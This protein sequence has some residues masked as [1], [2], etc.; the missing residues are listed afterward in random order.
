MARKNNS[1]TEKRIKELEVLVNKEGLS[2][3]TTGNRVLAQSPQGLKMYIGSKKA[4][5]DKEMF[6]AAAGIRNYMTKYNKKPEEKHLENIIMVAASSKESVESQQKRAT[7]PQAPVLVNVAPAPI[8]VGHRSGPEPLN[9]TIKKSINKG[10]I[11]TSSAAHCKKKGHNIIEDYAKQLGVELDYRYMSLVKSA[12]GDGV[13]VRITTKN[14]MQSCVVKE[15]DFGGDKKLMLDAAA[16]AR[17]VILRTGKVPSRPKAV[18]S[19]K[20]KETPTRR[21]GVTSAKIQSLGLDMSSKNLSYDAKNKRVIIQVKGKSL[22][23]VPVKAFQGNE[24]QAF[25][26]AYKVKEYILTENQVPGEFI[27]EQMYNEVR[28]PRPSDQ[29]PP[30][31]SAPTEQ[32]PK[33]ETTPGV[34]KRFKVWVFGSK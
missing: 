28:F 5:G 16:T 2:Y 22:L 15:N 26:A 11:T 24:I 8:K 23:V 25:R 21:T 1:K 18:V 20:A 10:I 3:D 12:R 32:E 9:T 29:N 33:L 6:Y 31:Y 30:T 34:F 27:K 17:R 19:Q 14:G 7:I 4:N 13:R